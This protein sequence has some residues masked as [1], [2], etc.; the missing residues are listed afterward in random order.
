MNPGAWWSTPEGIE[1]VRKVVEMAEAR[2]RGRGGKKVEPKPVPVPETGNSELAEKGEEGTKDGDKKKDSDSNEKSGKPVTPG[3][4]QSWRAKTSP[5]AKGP[6]ALTPISARQ[7]LHQKK[8]STPGQ[9]DMTLVAR[10]L[11]WTVR[12]IENLERMETG[13]IITA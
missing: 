6:K 3:S 1:K 8:P 4:G 11:R 13:K 2:K 5:A 10:Y 9:K 12:G 7:S